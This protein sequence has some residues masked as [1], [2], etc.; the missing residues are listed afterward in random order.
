MIDK[1]LPTS[2]YQKA[3][4]TIVQHDKQAREEVQTANVSLVTTD[5]GE[6]VAS[7]NCPNIQ[8]EMTKKETVYEEISELKGKEQQLERVKIMISKAKCLTENYKNK[9]EESQL[10]SQES[11]TPLSDT[12]ESVI[13]SDTDTAM[14][15]TNYMEKFPIEIPDDIP[16]TQLHQSCPQEIQENN[17]TTTQSSDIAEMNIDHSDENRNL[18]LMQNRKTRIRILAV[19]VLVTI[20]IFYLVAS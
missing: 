14:C 18:T 7:V 15:V 12:K 8:G 10:N 3:Y 2:N 19:M 1:I 17:F 16:D 9:S 6:N 4:D 11:L 5:M 13:I 20:L